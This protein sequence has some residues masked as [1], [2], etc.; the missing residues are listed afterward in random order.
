M[1]RRSTRSLLTV[2]ALVVAFWLIWS[3]LHFVVYVAIPWWGLLLLGLALFLVIDW[4]L[5]KL[6]R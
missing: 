1:N 6:V 5:A 3:R 2:L 4:L